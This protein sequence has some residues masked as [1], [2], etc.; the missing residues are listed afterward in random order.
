[1]FQF[2]EQ[3][4]NAASGP[5]DE[6]VTGGDPGCQELACRLS[7]MPSQ[8]GLAVGI[9]GPLGAL[10]RSGH[11]CWS[12][13]R[14]DTKACFHVAKLRSAVHADGF[15]TPPGCSPHSHSA[16]SELWLRF[17]HPRILV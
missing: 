10:A 7:N 3:L 15:P 17:W 1:M 16:D 5:E 11:D 9:E 13:E 2:S 4:L 14:L 6:R 8:A 12:L